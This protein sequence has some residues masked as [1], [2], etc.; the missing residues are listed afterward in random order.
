MVYDYTLWCLSVGMEMTVCILASLFVSLA[1]KI[2][3][4]FNFGASHSL[5]Y[6]SAF[7]HL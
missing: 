4:F 3:N 2:F 7:I 5:M 1:L 6:G